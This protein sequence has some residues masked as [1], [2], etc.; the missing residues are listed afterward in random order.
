MYNGQQLAEDKLQYSKPIQL[1]CRPNS[2]T[3]SAV[4]LILAEKKTTAS[5]FDSHA[6]PAAD[7]YE[8]SYCLL[9]LH[10]YLNYDIKRRITQYNKGAVT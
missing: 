8:M 7:E 4:G 5:C 6:L 3:Y 10:W 9:F 2:R 1:H